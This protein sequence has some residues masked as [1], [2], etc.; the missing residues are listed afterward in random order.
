[1]LWVNSDAGKGDKINIQMISLCYSLIFLIDFVSKWFKQYSIYLAGERTEV[2]SN[3]AETRMIELSQIRVVDLVIY[4][5][6]NFW[7][8]VQYQYKFPAY[9]EKFFVALAISESLGLAALGFK[10][11]I[12]I[13]ELKQGFHR[14]ID[15]DVEIKNRQAKEAKTGKK[16]N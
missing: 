10:L 7:L 11:L 16:K 4:W 1:M 9:F 13:I 5:Q 2:V 15:Y 12:N 3:E 14:I 8:I 6:V